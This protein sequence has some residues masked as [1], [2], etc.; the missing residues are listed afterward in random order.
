ML[1]FS[2]T[3]R[4][5]SLRGGVFSRAQNNY[6]MFGG[7]RVGEIGGVGVV[8]VNLGVVFRCWYGAGG[9]LSL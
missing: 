7:G 8:F 5:A 9:I 3:P 2:R 6:A 4:E 1:S